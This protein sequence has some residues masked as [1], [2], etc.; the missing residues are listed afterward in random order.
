[1]ALSCREFHTV[2]VGHTALAGRQCIGAEAAL[3][4][5]TAHCATQVV[6]V[7]ADGE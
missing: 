5:E 7:G 4:A 3:R 1:V 6:G 2:P